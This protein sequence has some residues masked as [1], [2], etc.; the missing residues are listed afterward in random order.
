MHA[1]MHNIL[2]YFDHLALSL[3]ANTQ[4]ERSRNEKEIINV[5][6]NYEIMK[7]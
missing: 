2:V 3:L 7:T 6:N 4:K 5:K 1:C